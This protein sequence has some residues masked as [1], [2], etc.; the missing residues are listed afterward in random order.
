MVKMQHCFTEEQ[1]KQLETLAKTT[2]RTKKTTLC[3]VID[4]GLKALNDAR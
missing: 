2:K 4:A 3:I 1:A